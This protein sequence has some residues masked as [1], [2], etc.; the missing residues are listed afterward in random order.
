MLLDV[1][2]LTVPKH[3]LKKAI[4]TGWFGHY[5]T[6]GWAAC[7]LAVWANWT[8]PTHEVPW[9]RRCA[10]TLSD[11]DLRHV[12]RLWTAHYGEKHAARGFWIPDW[13]NASFWGD[14]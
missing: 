14:P 9:K 7:P 4:V 3:E 1:S 13:L 8:A 11:T 5:V 12:I 10:S 2:K 6:R